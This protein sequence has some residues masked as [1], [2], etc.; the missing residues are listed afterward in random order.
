MMNNKLLLLILFS[1]TANAL[2]FNEVSRRSF[3]QSLSRTCGVIA[4]MV[5]PT[6]L[7]SQGAGASI[8]SDVRPFCVVGANGKTGTKCVQELIG[9][10]IPVRAT[11]RSGVYNEG[12]DSNPL[13]SPMVCD[14]T[15]LDTIQSSIEGTRAVI[16]AASASKGGGTPAQVDNDGLV[17]VAKACIAAK[18]PHLVVVSS[19]SVTK[20]ESPVFKFLNLFGK[21][22]EEKIKGEDEVRRLYSTVEGATYTIIRPGG[23]TEDPGRGASALELNQGDAKSGRISRFDVAALCIEATY[24]PQLTGRTT[25]ECYDADTGKSLNSVGASNILKQ[26]S[27]PGDFRTGYERNGETF[28]KLFTGLS[29]D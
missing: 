11:S 14:V 5:V 2:S 3:A 23:L 4:G 18:I 6:Q 13:L 7:I 26:K 21:I 29:K 8:A 9:M 17:N 16:F 24:Y 19:G 12:I 25:F 15:K 27:D 1:T 28:E 10:G 20:P 22:M